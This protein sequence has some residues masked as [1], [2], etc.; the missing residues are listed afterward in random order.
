MTDVHYYVL[1]FVFSDDLEKVALVRRNPEEPESPYTGIG[2]K[3][4]YGEIESEVMEQS[5]IKKFGIPSGKRFWVSSV[6]L[7]QYDC[8][9]REQ[10]VLRIFY[11]ADNKII[12]KL[13]DLKNPDLTIQKVS[14]LQ[15]IPIIEEL[16][17]IV[18]LLQYCKKNK[19]I[20]G[21]LVFE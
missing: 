4:H 7:F 19:K 9:L 17:V 1:G 11:K 8:E 20:T 21:N 2:G 15:S 10:K 6:S 12:K 14:E 5:F 3:V 18:P 16:T 13:K